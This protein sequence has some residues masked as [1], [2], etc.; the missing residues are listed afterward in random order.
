[1]IAA[2]NAAVSPL[3]GLVL[4]ATLG[5]LCLGVFLAF[6]RLVRGPS[7][8][9]RVVALDIIAALSIGIIAVYSVLTAAP[10]LLRV[11]AAL[12]LISF[13][14]TIAVARYLEKGVSR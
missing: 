10:E 5:V 14:G 8:P 6:L 13:L 7:A 9:D 4:Q 1:M 2:M 3:L 11:A 12:A